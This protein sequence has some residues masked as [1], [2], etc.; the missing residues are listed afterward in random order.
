MPALT[1]PESVEGKLR[2]LAGGIRRMRVLRGVCWLVLALLSTL[3][4]AVACDFLFDLSP[5]VR[6]GIFGVWCVAG[7][8][9]A[10]Y[11]VIRRAFGPVP[12]DQLARAVE[13]NYPSLAERLQT[14]VELNRTADPANGSRAMMAILAR[15]TERRTA[16]LNFLAA[17]P[18][19]YSLRLAALS[20]LALLLAAGPLLILPGGGTRLRRVVQPWHVPNAEPTFRL[21]VSSGDPVVKRGEGV[22][23]SG[24]AERLKADEPLPSEASVVLREKG[25][26]RTYPMRGDERGSFTFTKPSVAGDFEYCLVCGGL[27][28]EW[29]RVAV[30]DPAQI[31]PGTR[32]RIRPPGYAAATIPERTL[33]GLGEIEAFQFGSAAFDMKFQQPVGAAALQWKPDG[34]PANAPAEVIPVTL[35]PD[36]A[37]ATAEFPVRAD[38]TLRWVLE[39]DRNLRTEF[40]LAVRVIRDLP[41]RFEKVAGFPA[42]AKEIRP[43]EPLVF[44][45]SVR[46]D[47]AVA[48]AVLEY[49]RG[50][51]LDS[52]VPFSE[53]LPISGLGTAKGEGTFAFNLTNRFR[54]G[55]RIAFRIRVQDNRSLPGANLLPQ[56][57]VY[58]SQGWASLQIR[59]GAP[60]LAEQEVKG[61]HDALRER[62]AAVRGVVADASADLAALRTE[63]LGR[64]RLAADQSVRL[65][66]NRERASECAKALEEMARAV[67]LVPDLR[68][69]GESARR[70]AAADLRPAEDHLRKAGTETTSTGRDATATLAQRDLDSALAK[71]DDLLK[72]NER[73]GKLRQDRGRLA[74]LSEEQEKLAK[75]SAATVAKQ[76][77]LKERLEKTVAGS[78]F[79]KNA[80]TE[81]DRQER[82][83]LAGNLRETAESLR[84]LDDR[85]RELENADAKKKLDGVAGAQKELAEQV[86]ALA[87]KTEAAARLGNAPSLDKT[88][89]DNARE[90]I[91]GLKT[92]EALTEQEKAARE[93]DRIADALE[94]GSRERNDSKQAA[95][96]LERWQR[97]LQ[98]RSEEAATAH[99]NG[100]PEEIHEALRA[101][102]DELAK[103]IRQL[104]LPRSEELERLRREAADSSSN[105]TTPE[106]MGQSADALQRLSRSTPSNDQRRKAAADELQKLRRDQDA[107]SREAEELQRDAA[108]QNPDQLSKK[109]KDLGAKQQALAKKLEELDTPGEEPRRDRVAAQAKKAGN[110]L[111]RD[112]PQESSGPQKE[113][114]R[115]LDQLRDAMEG[116]PT[117]D[118]VAG[119]LA[120]MQSEISDK[121][122]RKPALDPDELQRLQRDQREIQKQLGQLAAPEVEEA[123][124][125]AREAVRQAEAEMQKPKPDLD[126]LKKKNR[127]AGGALD[128][129]AQAL[130]GS[131]NAGEVRA[132]PNKADVLP[133]AE[134]ARHA[135]EL[136]RKQRQLRDRLSQAATETPD[137][138]AVAER[139]TMQKQHTELADSAKSLARNLDGTED[140]KAAA[141]AARRA[142]D[143]IEQAGQNQ[144]KGK[145]A[146]ASNARR[147]ALDAI[148]EAT[149]SLGEPANDSS[150]ATTPE[151]LA[152][153]AGKAREAAAAMGDALRNAKD[154]KPDSVGMA[155]AADKL[156]QAAEHL[157]PGK[158]EGTKFE[159][160]GR[161]SDKPDPSGP[162]SEA[163]PSSSL[164][165]NLGKPWGELPGEVKAQITQ[166]LKARYGEDYARII[167]LYFEQL[168]ERK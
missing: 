55:D 25:A 80:T 85:A 67:D 72:Q 109:R 131:P 117:P 93:L 129:L 62:I 18:R 133:S 19:G 83:R 2:E 48:S 136:A 99:P 105:A 107:I 66:N 86:A 70:I 168:A 100:L 75:D 52:T 132:T 95:A 12:Q 119:E 64:P 121:L 26:E 101:E 53:A 141:E 68:G 122:Q 123:M 96:Q 147:K 8:A 137:A 155:G 138:G 156:K 87:K 84:K 111:D 17:A 35:S 47:I 112:S 27:R 91:E 157:A 23:L 34:T 106:G 24:Y 148:K 28:S 166:E 164:T 73:A 115:Q 165:A 152:K 127:E 59:S 113:L 102:Q 21:V 163:A 135:R 46:D 38:G 33:D 69:L 128:Q 126:E 14:L 94:K 143:W 61:Q 3:L 78:E 110:D 81:S 30:V 4:A 145:P 10:W 134:D 60:P 54:E 51:T 41:P 6:I 43:G 5:R 153:A 108:K 159:A 9:A 88:A 20:L 39:G 56:D 158:G 104:P 49:G 11:C 142:A 63:I 150:G 97:D 139:R 118:R 90:F 44:E 130:R 31:A 103:K 116:K 125:K 92:T 74:Q 162:A 22:T 120:R 57:A 149:E 15:D 13:A 140:T 45:L 89:S 79:L 167:K 42:M 76:Q 71:L 58:P 50:E 151:D 161:P 154:G 114:K 16:R 98:R 36:R 1:M 146:E 37:S 7:L 82:K 29:R 40:P 77:E 65:S 32:I 160:E 144:G 124:A